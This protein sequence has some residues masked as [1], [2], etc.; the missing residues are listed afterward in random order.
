MRFRSRM[1]APRFSDAVSTYDAAR[2]ALFGVPYDHTCSFRGDS[3]FAPRAIREASYN[4]ETF[5]MDH[6]RD[7]L[8]VPVADLGDTPAFGPTTEMVGG[9]TK[10]ASDVVGAGK[11][12]IVVGGEHSLAPAVVRAFPKDVGVIGIDAHLD[13]RDQYLEDRWSHACSARRIADH[14]GVEHVVYMGV[15]SYSAEEREDLERLGLTYVSVYDI[16]DRGMTAGAERA[17]KAVSRDKIYLTIDMDGV[18]P[19]YA[20]A[21]G[22]PEPFGL[23]PLQVKKLIGTLGPHLVGMDLNEVSPAWHFGQAALLGA[24]L[25]REAIMAIG[26]ARA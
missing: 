8:E 16:H 4:F 20:P 19:A 26:E 7:L 11:I 21:V 18:D 1:A 5:M 25:I 23:S 24:R 15:R 6:Q 3:R 17:L 10:M 13:F 14:V 22:N 2:L 12:P 9:V